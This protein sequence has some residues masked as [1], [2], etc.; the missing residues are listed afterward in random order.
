MLQPS[1]A[2]ALENLCEHTMGVSFYILYCVLV[3]VG[4]MRIDGAAGGRGGRSRHVGASTHSTR[5]FRNDGQALS[6]YKSHAMHL[7]DVASAKCKR[8]F[9][10]SCT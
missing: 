7:H 4:W 5:I 8:L 6:F 9:Y 3:S 1:G 10:Y 2:R